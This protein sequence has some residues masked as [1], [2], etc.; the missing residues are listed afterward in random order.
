[1][2]MSLVVWTMCGIFTMFGAY[3]YAELGGW[4]LP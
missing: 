1:V 3:C 4:L 2:N